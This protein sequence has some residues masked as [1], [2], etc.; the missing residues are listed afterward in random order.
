MQDLPAGK[1]VLITGATGRIGRFVLDD[2]LE[3]GYLVRA[4]TSKAINDAGKGA[5]GLEWRHVDFL[6]ETDFDA[7][8]EGC[9]AVLHLAAEIGK[10]ERMVRVNVDTTRSLAEASERAGVSIFCYTSS[11]SVYGS[12]LERQITETS[13]VLTVERDERSEYW[14]LEYVRAY[15]RTKLAGELVLRNCAKNVRYVVL[16]PSV[17]VDIPQIIGVRDWNYVKRTLAAHRHAHHIYVRDVSDA[18]IWF[19][20]RGMN[21]IGKP[22]DIEVFNVSEDEFTEPRHIDFMRKAFAASGDPRFRVFQAPSLAD[23]L[24]DFLRFRTLPLRNPLWR[25]RFSNSR[26]KATGY[27]FPFGMEKAETAALATLREEAGRRNSAPQIR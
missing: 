25:M 10:A 1:R 13:P 15:G 2:L 27:R 9:D 18:M 14:A 17:V 22:G 5:N 3:R 4:T 11:V 26:L 23:W 21:G 24:H 19:M 20:E 8:L 12:G 6:G 16:R 7:L